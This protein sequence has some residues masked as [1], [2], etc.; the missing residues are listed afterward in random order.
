MRV[1]LM[2][3]SVDVHTVNTSTVR[4]QEYKRKACHVADRHRVVVMLGGHF[5]RAATPTIVERRG[6]MEIMFGRFVNET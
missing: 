5:L 1:G 2:Q 4:P 6:H 3:R